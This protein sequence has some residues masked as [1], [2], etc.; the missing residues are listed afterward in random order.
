MLITDRF[1][2]I[3]MP[4]TG[5]TFVTEVLKRLHHPHHSG[6]SERVGG[7]WKWIE[8]RLRPGGRGSSRYGA[9]QDLEPKHG[10]CHDIPEPHGSKPVIST[11]RNPYDWYVSQYEFAWWKRT[12]MYYPEANPTPVGLAIDRV[13]P[14]FKRAN[15]HFPDVSF[16]EFM[17]LC[18]RAASVYNV[19]TGR[20]LGLY[21]HG[22]VR[23]YFRNFAKVLLDR[24]EGSAAGYYDP[25]ERFDVRFI[26]STHLNDELYGCLS[27]LG[28]APADLSFIHDLGR[29]LPMGI[30]RRDDQRWEGYYTPELK[31]RV[32]ERDR[33]LY[34]IFPEYND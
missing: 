8:R 29:I 33:M 24:C 3:H 17:D 30:G 14:D 12:D 9:I 25:T 15:P 7:G 23:F 19:G 1:V 4:K 27:S 26:D 18:D 11:M 6:R 21:T 28:Y 20:D 34:A 10:T 16:S 22:F 13:L 32:R 2:Y 31:A 5:G